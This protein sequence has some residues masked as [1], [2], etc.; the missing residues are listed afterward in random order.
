MNL[1]AL[2]AQHNWSATAQTIGDRTTSVGKQDA[3]TLHQS[4]ALIHSGAA[5]Y[6]SGN[7]MQLTYLSFLKNK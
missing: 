1:R 4:A 7:Y 3:T 5:R 6:R 2:P